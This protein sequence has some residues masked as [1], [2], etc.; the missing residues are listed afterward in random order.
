M[1]LALIPARGGSKRIPRKNVRPFNGKPIIAYSIAAALDSGCVDRV[2]VSTDD[3]EIADVARAHGAE[4]PFVRPPELS[5][6]HTHI[7]KVLAHA[8][9]WFLDRNQPPDLVCCLFATAPFLEPGT[10]REACDRLRSAPDKL[11]SFGVARFSFPIQ[12]AV[13]M[14][15]GGG[16][17]PF[18]PECMGMRSQDLEDAYHDAGQFFWARPHAILAGKSIFSPQSIPILI[19]SHRV[20]DIDTPEDWLR[21]ECLHQAIALSDSHARGLPS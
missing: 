19:P 3:P 6:D 15:P 13:R 20:Q 10:L 12:R 5:D 18:Q 2:V 14:L 21:A 16:V 11:F 1:N 9:R 7:G 8:I 4:T 17:A